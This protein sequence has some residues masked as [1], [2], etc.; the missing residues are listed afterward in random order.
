MDLNFTAKVT[1]VNVDGLNKYLKAGAGIDI[2][3]GKPEAMVKYYL[4]PEAREWGIKSIAIMIS[5]VTVDIN[6]ECSDDELTADEIDGLVV[7][8]GTHFNNGN[9]E[10][11]ISINSA[12]KFNDKSWDIKNETTFGEDGSLRIEEVTFDLMKNEITIS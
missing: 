5:S 10:G 1:D 2:W 4:D 7:S 3:A 8:G 11:T 9:I 12:D 6:W